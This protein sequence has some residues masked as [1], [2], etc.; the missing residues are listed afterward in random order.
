MNYI[1]ELYRDILGLNNK[2]EVFEALV[3]DVKDTIKSYNYFVKWEKVL[4]N[5]TEVEIRLNILNTLIGKE[6]IEEE[7]R[8]I[9]KSYPEVLK[10]VPILI[11]CRDNVF[12]VL[13]STG[14]S[15]F[16][17]KEYSFNKR[18]TK[19]TVLTDAEIESTIEF[20]TKVGF[21]KLLKNKQIKNLVDYVFG[22]ETGLDSN[23]RKNRTG[24]AMEDVCELLVSKM[25]EANSWRYLTQA[26]VAKIKEE[27]GIVVP[28]DKSKRRYDFAINNNGKILLVEVNFFN[29]QGSK[30]KS[31]AGEFRDL[32]K[33]IQNGGFEF[34]WITD[35]QGWNTAKKPLRD[36][37]DNMRQII[38]L[39]MVE[40]GA[41]EYLIKNLK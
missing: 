19:N 9:L 10:V 15:I 1:E 37:F 8:K 21:L 13:D 25:C 20:L 31:V 22:I 2:D 29:G 24:T 40:K 26:T 16:N 18:I 11:A 27:W 30:L 6:N 7:L 32:D 35:G 39:S 12:K 5:T 4:E 34:V 23:G 41:L 28:T 14:E 36:A 33:Y 17:Y 3:T 38:N